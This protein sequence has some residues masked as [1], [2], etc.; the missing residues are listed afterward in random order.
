MRHHRV[1]KKSWPNVGSS[2]H[3]LV[4]PGSFHNLASYLKKMA[5]L[6]KLLSV[7]CAEILRACPDHCNIL[8]KEPE[9]ECMSFLYEQMLLSE[10]LTYTLVQHSIKN[11]VQVNHLPFT[12]KINDYFRIW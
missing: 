5:I 8:V 7:K 9:V 4:A 10:T 12:C 11:I 6:L 1:E 2:T 3:V